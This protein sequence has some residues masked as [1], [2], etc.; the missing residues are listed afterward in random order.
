M[1]NATHGN[2]QKKVVVLPEA[3]NALAFP[4]PRGLFERFAKQTGICEITAEKLFKDTKKYLV[5]LR[6]GR[7]T[8]PPTKEVWRMWEAFVLHTRD[9]SNFCNMMGGPSKFIHFDPSKAPK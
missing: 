9:Y 5:N 3:Q 7:A 1:V 6:F 8:L 4:A 2:T